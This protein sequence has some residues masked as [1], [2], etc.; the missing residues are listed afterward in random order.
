MGIKVTAV[1]NGAMDTEAKPPMQ[2]TKAERLLKLCERRAHVVSQLNDLTET[3]KAYD[4]A[5]KN[6]MPGFSKETVGPYH[7]SYSETVTNR[8][9]TAKVKKDYPDI[10]KE[11][12]KQ[13]VGTR[14]TISVAKEK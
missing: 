10:A 5:I 11:C 6:S 12:T 4:E 14:L 8:I 7:I 2:E 3:K 1:E 13:T 9:D